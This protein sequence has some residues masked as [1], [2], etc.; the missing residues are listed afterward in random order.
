[1]HILVVRCTEKLS[2]FSSLVGVVSAK[3]MVLR[4]GS[5]GSGIATLAGVVITVL[6]PLRVV[7][8]VLVLLVR[9]VREHL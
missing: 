5:C 4:C 2:C 1:M 9:V 7:R 8:L 6:P 3:V